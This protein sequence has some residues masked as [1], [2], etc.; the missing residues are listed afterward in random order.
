MTADVSVSD[1]ARH[2]GHMA[3]DALATLAIFFVLGVE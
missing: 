2:G 1:G 3:G